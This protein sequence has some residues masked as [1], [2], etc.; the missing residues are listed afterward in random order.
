MASRESIIPSCFLE[1]V[2]NNL[3]EGCV[4]FSRLLAGNGGHPQMGKE[5]KNLLVQ[6][7]FTNVNATASFDFF[8]SKDDIVFLH[9]FIRDWF[10]L[11]QVIKAAT[12]YGLATHEQFDQWREALDIWRDHAGAV[13][14]LAFGEAIASKP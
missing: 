11:P 8:G 5:L 6:A 3:E 4:T 2:E 10:F 1:P 9:G 7:G 12:K 13:G 14:G